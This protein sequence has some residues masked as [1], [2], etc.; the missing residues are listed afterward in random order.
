MK[1]NIRD[2]IIAVLV[3][4]IFILLV[5]V[6][7]SENKVTSITMPGKYVSQEQYCNVIGLLKTTDKLAYAQDQ[8]L[9]SIGKSDGD[10]KMYETAFLSAGV[11]EQ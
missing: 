7:A 11:C 1:L 8:Y 4:V 6:F 2:L 3:I 10:Y 9:Y 5:V